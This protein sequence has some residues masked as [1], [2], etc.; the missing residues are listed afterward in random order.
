MHRSRS[1]IPST[2]LV[3]QLC[4]DGFNSGVKGLIFADM[5]RS[6]LQSSSWRYIFKSIRYTRD[7]DS[8]ACVATRYWLDGPGI[9]SRWGASLY[10]PVQT[11]P[12]AHPTSCIKGTGS[13]PGVESG[14]SV[15][16]T[17]HPLLV[18]RS[19]NSRVIPLLYVRVFVAYIKGKN[20]LSLSHIN[21]YP[22]VS[23]ALAIIIIRVHF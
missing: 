5:F 17:P 19:K 22:Y 10:V 9:E 4:A 11:G 7:R 23:I 1:K 20:Y 15:T 21:N 3:R 13:F 8:S 16:L 2:K 18:P 6:L 14:R 12:G